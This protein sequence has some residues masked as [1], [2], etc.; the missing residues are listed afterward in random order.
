MK[1]MKAPPDFDVS[2][3]ISKLKAQTK[4]IR[5]RRYSQRKSKLDPYHGEII[6]LLNA[7][8]SGAEIRRWLLGLNVEISPSTLSR[9]IERNHQNG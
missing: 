3:E 9:W 7:G 1:P 4:A 2:E 6:Q 8:A 5:K